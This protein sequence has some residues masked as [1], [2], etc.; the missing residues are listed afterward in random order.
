MNIE[1]RL[2]G[3][4]KEIKVGWGEGKEVIGHEYDQGTLMH[5]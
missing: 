4:R 3:K 5:V 1:G 2:L